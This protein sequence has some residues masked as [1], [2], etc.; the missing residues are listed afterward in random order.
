MNEFK[1]GDKIAIVKITKNCRSDLKVGD[2]A[3][4]DEL[5]FI[6]TEGV[7]KQAAFYVIKIITV[8]FIH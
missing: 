2:T 6:K 3:I 8:C 7:T 4:I 5:F 1:A